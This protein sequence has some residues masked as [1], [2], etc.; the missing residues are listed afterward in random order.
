[1][2]A[3][4]EERIDRLM[5]VFKDLI[6]PNWK[7]RFRDELEAVAEEAEDAE[8]NRI[9]ALAGACRRRV[10]RARKISSAVGAVDD[11]VTEV[12]RGDQLLVENN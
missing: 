5:V 10:A 1:M 4:T 3:Q 7:S 8:R 12:W 2:T 6:P 11:L 9:L